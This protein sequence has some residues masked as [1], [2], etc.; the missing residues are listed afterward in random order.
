MVYLLASND[1]FRLIKSLGIQIYLLLT[2]KTY[3]S[4]NI[5]I[6]SE[7]SFKNTNGCNFIKIDIK[8]SL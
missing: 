1:E 3:Y 6:N 7:I 5:I 2:M 8:Y 4:L